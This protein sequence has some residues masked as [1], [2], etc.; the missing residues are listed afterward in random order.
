MYV[1][2]LHFTDRVAYDRLVGLEKHIREA[3]SGAYSAPACRYT[4][5]IFESVF[6]CT[7]GQANGSCSVTVQGDA[8]VDL[9]KH[10]V[11]LHKVLVPSRMVDSF[12][13]PEN[14]DGGF[15]LCQVMGTDYDAVKPI[16]GVA[17]SCGQK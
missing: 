9:Y 2:V 10:N 15:S 7:G 14:L 8:S 16:G 3:T 12:L 4:D 11:I 13:N 5:R 6:I 17:M 1:T